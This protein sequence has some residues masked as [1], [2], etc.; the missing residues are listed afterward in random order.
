MEGPTERSARRVL[1]GGTTPVLRSCP[2]VA[3]RPLLIVPSLALVFA[4]AGTARPRVQVH[5]RPAQPQTASVCPALP[6]GA[7]PDVVASLGADANYAVS[8][9]PK[10]ASNTWWANTSNH[11]DTF[12]VTNTGTCNDTYTFSSSKTGPIT[13]V[14]LNKASAAL[15]AGG[16]PKRAGPRHRPPAPPGQ[17]T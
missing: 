17:G 10:G 12:T 11:P 4:L 7:D 14:S 1:R 16:P 13:G 2:V 6:S 15:T 9:T 5:R 8:V 3:R